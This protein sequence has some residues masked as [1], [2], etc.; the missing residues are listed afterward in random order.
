MPGTYIITFVW[1]SPGYVAYASKAWH[2]KHSCVPWRCH[3]VVNMKLT[4]AFDH[5]QKIVIYLDQNKDDSYTPETIG[6]RAGTSLRDLQD[7]RQVHFDKPVGWVSFD[8]TNDPN[9]DGVG[10]CV[11][12]QRALG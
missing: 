7:V 9:D 12:E 8:V 1:H 10:K 5:V 3:I 4:E 6:I 2:I 11:R